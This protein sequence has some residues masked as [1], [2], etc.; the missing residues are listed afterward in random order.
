M[1]IHFAAFAYQPLFASKLAFARIDYLRSRGRL[2]DKTGTHN[3]KKRAEKWTK[4]GGLRVSLSTKNHHTQ[5]AYRHIHLP[6]P[7]ISK[8]GWVR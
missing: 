7:I 4:D 5:R 1:K 8:A 2:V 3:V 6:L